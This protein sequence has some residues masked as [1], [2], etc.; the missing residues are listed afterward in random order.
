MTSHRYLLFW[1]L[2]NLSVY[3]ATFSFNQTQALYLSWFILNTTPSP[4]THATWM[5]LSVFNS[6]YWSL[7]SF[8]IGLFFWFWDHMLLQGRDR[9]LICLYSQCLEGVGWPTISFCR[10]LRGITNFECKNWK[11]LG[12]VR[13]VRH[14]G[15]SIQYV[16]NKCWLRKS[17]MQ[18]KFRLPA[19]RLWKIKFLLL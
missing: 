13:W 10:G 5:E 1:Y 6:E 14:T 11:I 18:Q 19:S 8:I 4:D 16:F 3:Y 15:F 9:V 2:P 17:L 12:K 7:Q